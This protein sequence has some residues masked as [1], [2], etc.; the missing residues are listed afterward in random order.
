MSLGWLAGFLD[1][2]SEPH[3]KHRPM[4]VST[5]DEKGGCDQEYG[6]TRY[7]SDICARTVYGL[8]LAIAFAS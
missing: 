3:V 4:C 6:E 7:R 8:G 2:F 1:L 5:P